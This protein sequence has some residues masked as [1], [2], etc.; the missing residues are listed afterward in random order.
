MFDKI[1][2]IFYISDEDKEKIKKIDSL[3][4]NLKLSNNA[5]AKN[6]KTKSRVRS[7]YS[8]LAIEDNSLSLES[9]Q[10]INDGKLVF[11]K[12]DEV[13]EVKNA[14]ELYKNINKYNFKSE[15]DFLKAHTLLMKYF[16]D[17]NGG[18][19]THGEAV[20]KDDQI[21]FKAPD[22]ILV[23]SLMKSLFEYINSADSHPLIL[24]ALFHYYLV[25]IHPFTDGN[26]R[27]ARFWSSLIL[28]S[29]DKNFEYLPLEEE[30]YLNQEKYYLAISN[31]HNNGNANLFIS[32]FL[33]I[34]LICIKKATKNFS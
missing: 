2:V 5:K 1:E 19:R 13:Q 12:K 4:S 17:D 20:K 8:S 10:D 18:Y 29:Y 7:I 11:G 30:I 32:F 27:I 16:E 31:S 34:T 28:I 33:D 14:I 3:L 24:A 9:V 23:P 15:K 25:Y 26:G 6:L 21:I 22:S